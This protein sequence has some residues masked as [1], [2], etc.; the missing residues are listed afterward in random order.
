MGAA[1]GD[2]TV[3]AALGNGQDPAGNLY[4]GA[5]YGVKTFL[6]RSGHW[7]ALATPRPAR[8]GVVERAVFLANRTQPPLFVVA[9]AYDGARMDSALGDFLAAASG[10]LTATAPVRPADA[11]VG[12]HVGGRSDLVCFVG[13]NGLMDGPAPDVPENTARGNPQAAVVLACRSQAFF[14]EPLRRARCRALITTTGLMAPEAYTL[15]AILRAWAAGQTPARIR[16]AAANAYAKYQKCPVAAAR[17][18]FHVEQ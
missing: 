13:H 3:P 6:I 16:D 9:D 8:K 18:L 1:G 5:M 4:W 2:S 11:T 12:V 10:G 15:D 17:R 7:K 14:A